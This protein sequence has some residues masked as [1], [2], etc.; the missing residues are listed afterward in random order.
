MTDGEKFVWAATFGACMAQVSASTPF[1]EY[2]RRIAEA[3]GSASSAVAGLKRY[4][5]TEHDCI[6]AGV[7]KDP[8]KVP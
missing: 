7:L 3:A 2:E 5:A 6:T 1:Q 4:I 8:P